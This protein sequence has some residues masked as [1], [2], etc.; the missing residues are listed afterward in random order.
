MTKARDLANAGTALTTVSATELGYL[1]GVTSAVQTQ[2][3][4]KQAVVSG[5]NDTEIG[6]LD[7]VTSAVQTQLDAKIAKSLA[8]AKGDLLV[9]TGSGTIV[10]QAVGTNGQVLTANS[11]QADGV[12]WATVAATKTM[13]QVATGSLTG[14]NN[15]SVTGLSAYDNIFIFIQSMGWATSTKQVDIRI[16]NS[17]ASYITMGYDEGYNWNS[18]VQ[19]GNDH[20]TGEYSG[21]RTGRDFYQN[22]NNTSVNLTNCKNTGFTN[23]AVLTNA[24]SP[25]QYTRYTYSSQ[26]IHAVAAGVSSINIVSTS[27]TNFNGGTYTIYAG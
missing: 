20:Y 25:D 11:A 8:T 18:G 6:Y 14:S 19:V 9:A 3:N 24:Q 2:I 10:A 26:G 22:G 27:G 7:G 13:S 15:I 21:I 12:E 1:D 16:N 23:F 17:S 5:V 4:A